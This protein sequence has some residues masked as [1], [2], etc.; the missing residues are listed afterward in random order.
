MI[1]PASDAVPVP[2]SEPTPV[3]PT[4]FNV[5]ASAPTFTPAICNCAP[6]ATVVPAAVV[7]SAVELAAT[8]VPALMFVAP[9]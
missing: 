5:T 9:A 6:L 2:V 7:P 8:S 3:G 1:A 4:P